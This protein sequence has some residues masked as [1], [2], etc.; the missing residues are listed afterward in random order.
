[1]GRARQCGEGGDDAAVQIG[2]GADGD[3]GCKRAGVGAVFGVQ[4]EVD[5]GQFGGIFGGFFTL[6][7]PEPVG[8][9]R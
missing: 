4:D 5:V 8:G 2:V 6:Q 7:H 9:V 3:A 1:V